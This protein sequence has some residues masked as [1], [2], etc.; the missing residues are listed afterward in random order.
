MSLKIEK[1]TCEIL[2]YENILECVP[3][4]LYEAIL[5]SYPYGLTCYHISIKIAQTLKT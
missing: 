2:Q 4:Q 1:T 5:K 3:T